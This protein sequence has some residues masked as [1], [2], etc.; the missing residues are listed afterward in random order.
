MSDFGSFVI[1]QVANP[2]SSVVFSMSS[3]ILGPCLTKLP[4]SIVLR[5]NDEDLAAAARPSHSSL[6]KPRTNRLSSAVGTTFSIWE[7]IES[8][9]VR[10][11]LLEEAI[12][13]A[14][15][16]EDEITLDNKKSVLVVHDKGQRRVVKIQ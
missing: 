2:V 7:F 10:G 3:G 12:L 11:V 13:L 15:S 6:L 16:F 14:I 5:P 1:S 4:R 9:L 8:M